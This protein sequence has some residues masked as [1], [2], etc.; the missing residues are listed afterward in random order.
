[1]CILLLEYELCLSHLAEILFRT[2]QTGL[3]LFKIDEEH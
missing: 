3:K 2:N 1:M